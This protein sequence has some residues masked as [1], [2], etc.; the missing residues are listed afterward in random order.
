M[1]VSWAG[2]GQENPRVII[3]HPWSSLGHLTPVIPIEVPKGA[4]LAADV[5]SGTY[6]L[7][8]IITLAP[9]Q[10]ATLGSPLC[11]WSRVQLQKIRESVLIL[12][13]IC[14]SAEWRQEGMTR[15]GVSDWV[16]PPFLSMVG[17]LGFVSCSKNGIRRK[18]KL[19][20]QIAIQHGIVFR[21]G[22]RGCGKW[23]S[24][25]FACQRPQIQSPA[26]LVKRIR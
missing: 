7:L 25:C 16:F 9:E 5:F 3:S 23:W 19:K 13:A 6:F 4:V 15:W 11:L 21:K 20:H 8:S 17:G 22:W 14:F 2:L 12:Q 18:E 1:L 26:L 10:R 24:F